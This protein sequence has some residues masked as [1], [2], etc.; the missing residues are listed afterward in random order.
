MKRT[1]MPLAGYNNF[2]LPSNNPLSPSSFST[3]FSHFPLLFFPSQSPRSSLSF[4][5]YHSLLP[6][7][8]EPTRSEE[9]TLCISWLNSFASQANL[10]IPEL[11]LNNKFSC[12]L[13]R[14]FRLFRMVRIIVYFA[15][16]KGVITPKFQIAF[17]IKQ[18][19]CN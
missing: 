2:C 8:L 3:A 10:L 6:P 5:L 11:P 15:F 18:L 9:E 12:A 14:K 16:L 17:Q 19:H 1:S 13:S 4:Y 7:D